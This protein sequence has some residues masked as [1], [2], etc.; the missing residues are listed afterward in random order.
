MGEAPDFTP[1]LQTNK[2]K[3]KQLQNQEDHQLKNK[4]K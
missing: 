4:I 1:V 2:Q 3:N